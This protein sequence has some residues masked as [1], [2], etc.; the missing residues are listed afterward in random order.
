MEELSAIR[1][2]DMRVQVEVPGA[3]RTDSAPVKTGKE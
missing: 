2:I 3:R 1:L